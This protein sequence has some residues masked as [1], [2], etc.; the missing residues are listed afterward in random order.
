[1]RTC[2]SSGWCRG[3]S[4]GRESIAPTT[5]EIP[6]PQTIVPSEPS[7]VIGSSCGIPYSSGIVTVTSTTPGTISSAIAAMR[8]SRFA[9]DGSP[10]TMLTQPAGPSKPIS[11]ARLIPL[12]PHMKIV[13]P[14][15]IGRDSGSMN[16]IATK[17]TIITG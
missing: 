12:I 17:N 6:Q 16:P 9:R 8:P 13:I 10:V 5:I 15:I 11:L 3:P 4:W 2:P 1:M 7:T 14:S